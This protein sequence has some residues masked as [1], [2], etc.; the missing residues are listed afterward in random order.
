VVTGKA[1]L[2]CSDELIQRTF[3]VNIL[4]HFWVIQM[5]NNWRKAIK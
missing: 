5:L 4:A 2:E 1:L 3:D